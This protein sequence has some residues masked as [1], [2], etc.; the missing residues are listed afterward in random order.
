MG[1]EIKRV[2]LTFDWPLS[3]RWEGFL[4]PDKFD[5]DACPDCQGGGWSPQ[6]KHMHDLWYGRVPFDPA[7]TGSTPFTVDT[8]AVRAFAERNVQRAPDFYGIGEL[9]IHIEAR[10]LAD[11]FN[12][13]WSHHLS[14]E[15]VDALLAADRLRDLTHT[16]TRGEGWKLPRSR[17]SCRRRP[18]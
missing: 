5:E 17:P 16:W 2:P 6:A 4:R 7:S 8:P 12:A 14:Q 3:E 1:R 15:D 10:R 13:R 11:L 9:A 18:R